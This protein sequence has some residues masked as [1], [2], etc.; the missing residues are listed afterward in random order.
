MSEEAVQ[1]HRWW[2]WALSIFGL[3]WI[4]LPVADFVY[5]D[6]P[7]AWALVLVG[8]ALLGFA[9]QFLALVMTA[10]AVREPVVAMVAIA[11]VLTLAATD[12]FALLFIYAA[13]AA[14]VRL[15]GR[16]GA[17]VVASIAAVGAAAVAVIDPDSALFWG[18]TAAVVA[19]G[20]LWLLIRGLL[21]TNA[22]LREA[23][24]ELAE[25]AVAEE[26]LR[27]ARDMHDLL[28][29]DL[30]L[31]AIKAELA[32]K[33][34]ARDADRAASEIGDIRTLSRT[35]LVQ[36]RDAV[37]GYRRPTL[38]SELAGARVA[39][40]AAGIELDVDGPGG[41]L[42][43]EAEAVLA[44]AVRE[45][46]TNVI[47]HSGARRVTITLSATTLEMTDD[48]HDVVAGGEAPAD[49]GAGDEGHGLAGLVERAAAV[50]G[51]VEAGA[52]PDGGFRLRVSVP[53][54]MVAA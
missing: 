22:A 10:R 11:V 15:E 36:V 8:V 28:G 35:A 48:G 44:W 26:R 38:A 33:L 51:T 3:L 50:G 53:D 31:I 32:G 19:T 52:E 41:A 49:K 30:S 39:L 12:S 4:G 42:D 27:F 29:H 37:E 34:V 13:S 17:L 20:T 45:G 40:E 43:P 2:E 47:R 16:T 46:A 21:R 7:P 18:V 5:N 14:S 54:R 9:S 24:E 25:L 1:H 23:R 6:D